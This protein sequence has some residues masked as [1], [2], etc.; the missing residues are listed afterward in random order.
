MADQLAVLCATIKSFHDKKKNVLESYIPF[1]EH[2]LYSNYENDNI[3]QLQEF[4]I[5][6]YKIEIPKNSLITML[7]ILKT[8]NYIT[9]KGENI[10]IL[11]D[12][13]NQNEEYLKVYEKSR[14][15]LNEFISYYKNNFYKQEI[16]DVKAN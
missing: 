4:I 12:M 14:R 8:N 2:C 1:I 10:E 5:S 13:K 16:S 9:L 7:N 11:K 3:S 15:D 6:N